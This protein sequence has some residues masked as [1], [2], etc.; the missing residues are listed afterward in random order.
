MAEQIKNMLIGVFVV[1][2]CALIVWIILFLKP[3]VGNEGEPLFVRFADINKIN[4]GTRVTFAGRPVGEVV[5]ITEIKDARLQPVDSLGDIYFYELELRVDTSVE[6]FD[7]D[8]V[9]LQTSGRLGEKSVAIMPRKPPKGVTPRRITTQ[10]IYAESADPIEQAFTEITSVAKSAN[11]VLDQL[12]HWIS[13][14]S[15]PLSSAV[16]SFGDAMHQANTLLTSVNK[17]RL[18]GDMS[19]VMSNVK[20]T[21]EDLAK[22]RGTIGKLIK[23]D[24]LYLRITSLMTKADTLMNDINH[25]GLLFNLNK[26]WQRSRLKR[27]NMLSALDSP[28]DFRSFFEQ[29][30]DQINLA[31]SRLSMMIDKAQDKEQHL[32]IL[33][34]PSFRK[35]FADLLRQT[36]GL[37]DNLKLYNEQLEEAVK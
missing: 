34:N 2:A 18:V 3:S 6:V 32:E 30:I 7:T 5:K 13:E 22:G 17:T 35:D 10:P 21:S 28:A 20:K 33:Q 26:T 19:D 16:S 25:Y 8:L 1:I 23:N 4:V 27:V 31:M 36:E 37:T 29:E 24:D 12:D 9:S 11:S 14:N 15:T